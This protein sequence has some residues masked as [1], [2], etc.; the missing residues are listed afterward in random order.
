MLPNSYTLK[1][2]TYCLRNAL[3]YFGRVKKVSHYFKIGNIRG[4]YLNQRHRYLKIFRYLKDKVEET[5]AEQKNF[6]KISLKFCKKLKKIIK[7]L[8]VGYFLDGANTL[9]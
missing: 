2:K 5:M 6:R 7:Y 4:L 1:H 9:T 3:A 8:F